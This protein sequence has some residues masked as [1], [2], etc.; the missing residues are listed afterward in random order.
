MIIVVDDAVAAA[1]R[2]AEFDAQKN[3][4][5]DFWSGIAK[6]ALAAF[7][8]VAAVA[9]LGLEIVDGWL[10]LREDGFKLLPIGMSDS[11]LLDFPPGHPRDKVIYI[12]HP[13]I[14]SVYFTAAQ[15]HRVIFEHKFSEAIDLLMHLGA[16]NIRVEHVRGW[17]RDFAASLSTPLSTVDAEVGLGAGVER[18]SGFRLLFEATLEGRTG[19]KLPDGLVWY[20]HEPT[21]QSVAKGR[22]DFGLRNFSLNVS[23]E[24]DFGVN[25]GLKARATKAG[26]ELGGT[27]EA[28]HATSWN[29]HGTFFGS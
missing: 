22:L 3:D 6:A 12:G 19:P 21:W 8:P 14:P 9:S 20:R 16:T 7:S 2:Q 15:F 27:F 29:I 1:T 10:R 25:A 5:V 17:S 13:V 26:F 24:D 23:Y 11:S 4:N 28:H 18:Q